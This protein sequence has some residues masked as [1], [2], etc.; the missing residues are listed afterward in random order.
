MYYVPV[1]V[2]EPQWGAAAS[3][4]NPFG[5]Q[6]QEGWGCRSATCQ[7]GGLSRESWRTGASVNACV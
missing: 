4:G 6:S 2:G 5:M 1:S 3:E 7:H